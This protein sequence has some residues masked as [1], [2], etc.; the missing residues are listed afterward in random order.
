M[1]ASLPTYEDVLII[2]VITELLILALYVYIL[3]SRPLPP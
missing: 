2:L 3:E 1:E